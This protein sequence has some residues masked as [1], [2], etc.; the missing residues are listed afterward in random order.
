MN[1]AQLAETLKQMQD[2]GRSHPG[3][4]TPGAA[5]DERMVFSSHLTEHD[6]PEFSATA[7]RSH[8]CTQITDS[9]ENIRA[10]ENA[11]ELP[12]ITVQMTRMRRIPWNQKDHKIST[13]DKLRGAV[14]D[15]LDE[16]VDWWPLGPLERLQKEQHT[17]LKWEVSAK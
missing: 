8:I 17:K 13:L 4:F 15:C 11:A 12:P 5:D 3:Y 1:A 16:V 6:E 9:E 14:E 7:G 10:L 2:W